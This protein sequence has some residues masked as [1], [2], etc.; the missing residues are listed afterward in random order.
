MGAD[1]MVSSD[2]RA[3]ADA[4]RHSVVAFAQHDAR[5][6]EDFTDLLAAL[7]QADA[8]FLVV[9]AYALAVHGTPRATG[10]LDVWIDRT[11]AN[12]ARIWAAL[13]DFGAPV[14]AIGVS[15]TDL[16]KPG[17]VV[18]VGLPP[19]RIDVLTEISGITFDI[20]W[21][22]RVIHPIGALAVPFLGRAA[23]IANKRAAGR[24]KD[25]ADLDALRAQRD[26]D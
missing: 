16:T 15:E 8:R 9:G 3:I 18:Q 10:D 22:E 12:A 1:R 25:L 11:P 26:P 13:I 5:V 21:P 14:G 17:L 20:A 6:N 24:L 7:L 23:L 4:G 19:R 2:V